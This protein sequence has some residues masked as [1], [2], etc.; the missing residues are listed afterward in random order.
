MRLSTCGLF[1]FEISTEGMDRTL[2]AIEDSIITGRQ[3][4][5]VTA[6]SYGLV[7]AQEDASLAEVYRKA[8]IL[9]PDSSGVVWALGRKG[10]RVERVSGVDLVDR[11]CALSSEKGYR[12]FFLG[13]APGI[14]AIAAEKMRLKHPGCNIVGTRDGFFP[15]TDCD[16]VAQEVAKTNPD[17]LFVAMGIPRQE[18]FIAATLPLTGAKIA[19]GVGGSLDVHSGMVK[20]APKIVQVMNLEWM[21][22]LLLN[23]KKFQ[24]VARLPRFVWLVLRGKS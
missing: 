16:V 9:T 15:M 21:W 23:P 18:K 10:H 5:V 13:S 17:V 24:K 8:A 2:A 22:R 14:A 4:I 6:D 7:L 20:R 19:M 3:G 1:G 12:I 11:L